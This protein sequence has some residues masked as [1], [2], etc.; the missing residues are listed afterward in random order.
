MAKLNKTEIDDTHYA[1]LFECP[2]CE[3]AHVVYVKESAQKIAWDFNGDID[4]PT[5]SPSILNKWTEGEAHKVCHCYIEDGKIQ[6]LGDCTHELKNQ[7][8]ELPEIE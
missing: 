4:K 6:F 1:F 5:F 3:H 2:G 7:T 8:V